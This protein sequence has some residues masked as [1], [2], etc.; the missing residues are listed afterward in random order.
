MQA[1][2]QFS[3][4]GFA[5]KL[6]LFYAAYFLFGGI[7]LPFFPVW[8]EAKGLDPSSIGLVVAVPTLVR[9]FITPIGAH[10]ADRYQA[11]KAA[12]VISCIG[13]ALTMSVVGLV[14]GSIA[15]LVAVIVAA[16]FF[17]PTL[18]LTDAYAITGLRARARAYGPVRLWGSAAF[19]VANLGAGFLLGF[20]APDNLI[21]LIVAALL[22]AALAAIMLV[23][24]A[25]APAVAHA[26]PLSIM[27]LW[28]NPAFV[29]IAAAA[30]LTQGSH[31]AFYGF[32]TLDWRAGGMDGTTIGALWGLGVLAEIVLFAFA[33][34]LPTSIGPALLLAI[35]AFGACLRWTAMAFDPSAGV[36]AAL[37]LLHALSFGA[38][39]LGAIAFLSRA[40]PQEL[41]ATAQGTVSTISGIVMASATGI[42]GL[43]YAASGSFAYLAMAAMS[44]AGFVCA[45]TA[46]RVWRS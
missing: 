39:H 43:L 20:L 24:L 25:P 2:S 31:A 19:I 15:I 35:G 6:G 12:L 30:S 33:G 4:D 18:A 26:P 11:L 8:L 44:V 17:G 22:L 42:S 40:V 1:Q 14:D 28:R 23:P 41:V 7:Q 38:S 5:V 46:H 45:L 10:L 16:C 36:L 27:K 32:S 13:G 29:A 3:T 37:Q 9:I 34:R 21:W